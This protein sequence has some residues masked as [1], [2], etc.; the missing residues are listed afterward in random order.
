MGYTMEINEYGSLANDRVALQ[1]RAGSSGRHSYARRF[2][3]A[4]K[5]IRDEGEEAWKNMLNV[6][7][8]TRVR[9]TFL[10]LA[11]SKLHLRGRTTAKATF[12]GSPGGR[13]FRET[14]GY[15]I[16]SVHA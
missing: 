14:M 5:S 3:L 8:L 6:Y 2:S 9:L 15:T 11:Q 16:S 1:S 7:D 13:D 4:K 10:Y 12:V